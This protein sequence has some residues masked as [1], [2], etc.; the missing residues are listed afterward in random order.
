MTAP[1]NHV[2]AVSAGIRYYISNVFLLLI[3]LVGGE[4]Y[5]DSILYSCLYCHGFLDL[6]RPAHA[7]AWKARGLKSTM[8]S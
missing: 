7:D 6:G 8:R 2:V 5:I 3:L 1:A 4:A